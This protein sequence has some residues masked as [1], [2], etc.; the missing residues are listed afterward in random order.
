[1]RISDWSSD[2]CS[3]DLLQ[4]DLLVALAGRA[5]GPQALPG[6]FVLGVDLEPAQ[7]EGD[8]QRAALHQRHHVG[9]GGDLARGADIRQHAAAVPSIAGRSAEHTS[10]L[11]ALIRIS[12]AV[13][14]YTIHTRRR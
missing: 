10:V 6:G 2:V 1:M 7:F 4:V 9:R 11:Q 5:V 14:C 12:Y 13:L 8:G 3:S